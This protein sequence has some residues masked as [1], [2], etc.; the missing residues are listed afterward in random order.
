MRLQ[1]A[2]A[3]KRPSITNVCKYAIW[4]DVCPCQALG[5]LDKALVDRQPEMGRVCYSVCQFR[6]LLIETAPGCAS[7]E[8]AFWSWRRP[9]NFNRFFS[10]VASYLSCAKTCATT[11]QLSCRKFGT[12]DG[13]TFGGFGVGVELGCTNVSHHVANFDGLIFYGFGVW[14]GCSNVSHHIGC[15]FY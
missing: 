7:S 14:Q 1:D 15:T 2:Q 11:L 4:N 13:F 8:R 3:Q 5:L 10:C 12:A 9:V 6:C